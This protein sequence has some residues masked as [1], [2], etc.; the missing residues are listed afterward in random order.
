ML[1]H[2]V[3]GTTPPNVYS[4]ITWSYTQ[5]LFICYLVLHTMFIHLLPSATLTMHTCFYQNW[6]RCICSNNPYTAD[7]WTNFHSA[8]TGHHSPL[9]KPSKSNLFSTEGTTYFTP[10]FSTTKQINELQSMVTIK[11]FNTLW[12]YITDVLQ[13]VFIHKVNVKCKY[14]DANIL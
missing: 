9:L 5:C 10:A 14:N 2:L 4:S 13:I 7:T 12:K 8:T 11:T 1:I 3:P 6:T